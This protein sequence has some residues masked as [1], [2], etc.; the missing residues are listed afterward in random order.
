MKKILLILIVTSLTLFSCNKYVSQDDINPNEPTK[1]SLATVLPVVEISIFATY[2][3]QIARTSGIWMQHFQGTNFQMIDFAQYKVS[4]NDIQNDWTTIYNAGFGNVVDLIRDAEASGS[5]YYAGIGK[6]LKSMLL[7]IAT[8]YWGD[9]PNKEAG[10]GAANLTPKYETQEEILNDIQSLLTSAIVDLKKPSKSNAF[11]PAKDDFIG[12]GDSSKW[13]I[14]AN[15]LRA[16]YANRLSQRDAMGSATAA[17]SAIDDAISAGLIGNSNDANAVFSSAANET[18]SWA[19]FEAQR[20]GYLKMHATLV[21]FMKGRND[22][23]LPFYA[24]KDES[25][26]YSGTPNDDNATVSTSAI[27]SYYA[28]PA[29]SLPLVTFVEAK[30]IE[31]EAALRSGN[32]GR[33]QT[34]YNAALTASLNRFPG[35]DGPAVT[36]YLLA[37]GTLT[38]NDA[39]KLKQ[40]MEEKWVASFTQPEVF[41]DWRRTNLP[42]LT[43]ATNGAQATIPV[44][45]PTEQNERLYNPNAVVVSNI[46]TNVWWDN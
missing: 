13:I 16:R 10:L 7:G 11:L 20:A 14:T 44:R 43:P 30:F 35:V 22:P 15:I 3:G 25:D 2:T 28:S 8:D 24:G 1:A 5:P 42:T 40:I 21:D 32:A 39:N 41:S 36:A 46:T 38:G 45:F 18:N 33:A 27:G 26:G 37:N 4:E 6:V 12:G 17:L 34:A 9:I 29:S 19:A 31:A 23:R